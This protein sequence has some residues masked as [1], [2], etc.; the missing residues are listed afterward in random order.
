[1]PVQRILRAHPDGFELLGLVGHGLLA[2][3]HPRDQEGHVEAL[4]QIAVGRPVREQEDRVGRQPQAARSALRLL[5]AAK[6]IVAQEPELAN[7]APALDSDAAFFAARGEYGE[8]FIV[9]R[10]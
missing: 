10:C 6:G 2:L 9:L 1:M 8:R 4:G 5:D 7:Y 3:R